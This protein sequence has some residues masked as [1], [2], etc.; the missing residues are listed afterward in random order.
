MNLTGYLIA[1]L[2]IGFMVYIV[3]RFN[4]FQ[5]DFSKLLNIVGSLKFRVFEHEGQLLNRSGVY[6]PE[7]S[8]EFVFKTIWGMLS[9]KEQTRIKQE[10][11]DQCPSHIPL[12]KYVLY[13]YRVDTRLTRKEPYSQIDSV[14]DL[15]FSGIHQIK[16]DMQKFKATRNALA[17]EVSNIESELGS[18]MDEIKNKEDKPDEKSKEVNKESA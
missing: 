8:A 1:V 18:L 7:D 13:N 3:S 9:E 17:E 6:V 2:I 10:Y 14:D 16:H 5:K 4:H 15:I 12:W 11:S